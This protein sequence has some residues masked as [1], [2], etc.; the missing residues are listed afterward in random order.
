MIAK[1]RAYHPLVSPVRLGAVFEL[2]RI[3]Q[4]IIA[5]DSTKIRLNVMER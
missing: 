3:K 1:A 4:L 5:R 2:R